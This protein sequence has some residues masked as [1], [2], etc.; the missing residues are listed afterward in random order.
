[1]R[2]GHQRKDGYVHLKINGHSYY[3][4]VLVWLYIHGKWPI[5]IDHLDENKSNNRVL[6][7]LNVS[8]AE[9]MRRYFHNHPRS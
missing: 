3:A 1:M 9:N 6:N 4:H 8:Q 5:T 2:A 7:L